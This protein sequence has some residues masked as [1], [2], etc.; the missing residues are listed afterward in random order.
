[1]LQKDLGFNCQ[2]KTFYIHKQLGSLIR[3]FIAQ[4][5]CYTVKY[6]GIIIRTTCLAQALQIL[7]QTD[8]FIN[9]F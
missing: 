5:K 7:M 1:M 3:C 6:F 4:L 2:F 8:L 9:I